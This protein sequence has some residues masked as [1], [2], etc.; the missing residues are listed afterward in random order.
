MPR[1][2]RRALATPDGR[3]PLEVPDLAPARLARDVERWLEEDRARQDLT[4]LHALPAELEASGTVEAQAEG[5]LSG[6][7]AALAI[8][9]AMHLRAR[10]L[11]RDGDRVRRGVPVLRLDGRARDL[12]AAERTLLNLLMHLSG[13]ATATSRAVLAARRGRAGTIVAA[14]R[15]TL[16]GLRDLEKSAVVHG[17]GDPHRRDLSSSVLLKNNHLALVDLRS[18][19]VPLG[20][21]RGSGRPLIVE[22]RSAGDAVEVARRGVDRLLLDNLSPREVRA[23]LRSL[24]RSGLR[25]KVVVEVSGGITERNVEAYA[26]AGADVVSM[27]ALTH[28]AP[29]LP[30]HLVVLPRPRGRP[31]R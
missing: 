13:V 29:A 28:S 31:G 25:R 17:G 12:L 21:R 9:R 24:D 11:K 30:F 16:P 5:V 20:G 19:P 1:P 4:S 7:V 3:F 6:M 23:V 22:V 26:R 8:A 2:T 10:P 27:G 18:L 14:T 15:K